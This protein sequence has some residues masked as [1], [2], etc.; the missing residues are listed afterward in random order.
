[1]KMK[2]NN[3]YIVAGILAIALLALVLFNKDRPIGQREDI[4][5]SETGVEAKGEANL[6]WNANK[7]PDIAGYRIYYG[8]VSRQGDCPPGGY[9]EKI[10]VGN[11]TT[12]KVDNLK[13]ESTYYFSVTSYNKGGKESCFPQEVSKTIK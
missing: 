7:E 13:K 11:K 4:S 1:M 2:K 5:K 9:P 3:I 10:D 6:S 12:Y 8:T